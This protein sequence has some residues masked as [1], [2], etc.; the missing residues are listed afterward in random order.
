MS[1]QN[2]AFGCWFANSLLVLLSG[3]EEPYHTSLC[4]TVSRR[5]RL[6]LGDNDENQLIRVAC[7]MPLYFFKILDV[8]VER[9][10]YAIH[11]TIVD[12]CCSEGSMLNRRLLPLKNVEQSAV[13][14]PTRQLWTPLAVLP[15][16][17]LELTT[18]SGFGSWINY[19]SCKN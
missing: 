14:S 9:R 15:T 19:I 1:I 17:V 7:F 16:L 12:S 13:G 11:R 18:A 5:G 3:M 8:A 10:T 4:R 6:E 2:P